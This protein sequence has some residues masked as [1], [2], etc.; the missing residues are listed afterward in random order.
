VEPDFHLHAE[1]LSRLA[2]NLF[3]RYSRT[4]KRLPPRFFTLLRK[5]MGDRVL[6]VS[7]Y[8]R[9]RLVGFALFV[10]DGAAWNF[11]VSGFDYGETE[12][13]MTYFNLVFYL[14][15]G[16]AAREGIRRINY[17]VA[18]YP[19]KLRRGCRLEPITMFVKCR[20]AAKKAVFFPASRLAR[21]RYEFRG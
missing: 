1:T 5:N 11:F 18:T 20:T 16:L 6:V 13:T 2:G 17:G 21:R 3:L 10:R 4:P 9:D 7:A 14:P 19:P 15:I 8:R 12:G